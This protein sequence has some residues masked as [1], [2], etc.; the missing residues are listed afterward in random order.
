MPRTLR[1]F[2]IAFDPEAFDVE[3]FD[4]RPSQGESWTANSKQPEIWTE[5]P[6]NTEEWTRNYDD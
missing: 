5:K 2:S 4:E 1:A 3:M 6:K